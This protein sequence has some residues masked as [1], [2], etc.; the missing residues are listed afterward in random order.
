MY[1]T[2]A[3]GPYF[4]YVRLS[5]LRKPPI[6]AGDKTFENLPYYSRWLTLQRTSTYYSRR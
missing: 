2:S 3:E 1:H 5:Y 4:Y 6:A